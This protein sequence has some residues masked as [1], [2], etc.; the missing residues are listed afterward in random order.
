M[1]VTAASLRALHPEFTADPDAVVTGAIADA[2]L[3]VNATVLGDLADTA[4]T[5]LACH[6]IAESPYGRD[7]RQDFDGFEDG[8]EQKYLAIIE[9][10]GRA[11]RI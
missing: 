9:T 2:T 11:Y 10:S 1:T 7:R 4:I 5:W 6:L 8:Y 3:R